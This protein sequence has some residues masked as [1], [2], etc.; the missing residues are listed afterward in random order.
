[1][2]WLSKMEKLTYKKVLTWEIKDAN[3]IKDQAEKGKWKYHKN[4]LKNLKKN[5]KK[6][7]TFFDKRGNIFEDQATNEKILKITHRN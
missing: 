1:M 6:V 2:F 4:N 5:S 7:L 3:I